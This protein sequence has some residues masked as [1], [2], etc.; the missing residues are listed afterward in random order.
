[1]AKL[2]ISFIKKQIQIA[3]NRD[4]IHN[5]TASNIN[6]SADKISLTNIRNR[7]KNAVN[8]DINGCKNITSFSAAFKY[9]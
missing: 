1:M 8:C 5:G 6:S 9:G 2:K 4:Y 3:N 7:L